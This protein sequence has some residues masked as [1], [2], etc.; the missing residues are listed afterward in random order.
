MENMVVG[1]HFLAIKNENPGAE[2]TL[3]FVAFW[4][5]DH[6][7]CSAPCSLYED[8]GPELTS[9]GYHVW[10]FFHP[11][12][13]PPSVW[14]LHALPY[15]GLV[16]Q[17]NPNP[18]HNDPDGSP[19]D[20]GAYGGPSADFSYLADVDMDQMWD[21]WE[22]KYGLDPTD[23]FDDYEDLDGDG[24]N[25]VSEFTFG[26]L[27]NTADSDGDGCPEGDTGFV[28]GWPRDPDQCN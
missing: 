14:D 12:I 2:V 21:G 17:G 11:N 24:W 1:D 23:P 9:Y 27:P 26:T 18:I 5:N 25:N 20:L 8:V 28:D 22:A 7:Y 13:S 6:Q 15:G 10:K 4:F 3:S 16:D 19:N